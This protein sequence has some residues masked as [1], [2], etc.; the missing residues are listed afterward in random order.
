MEN[1]WID[2]RL[3]TSLVWSVAFLG[4]L[5]LWF[6]LM[7]GNEVATVLGAAALILTAILVIVWHSRVRAARRLHA[8]LNA[9][10]EREIDRERRRNGPPRARDVSTRWNARVRHESVTAE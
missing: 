6:W 9:Y 3:L 2:R 4:A 5:G 10:A 8:A 1:R 7:N